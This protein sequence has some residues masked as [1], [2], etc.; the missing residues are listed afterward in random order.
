M[1]TRRVV[2]LTM[3]AAAAVGGCFG[4]ALML[5]SGTVAAGLDSS[6]GRHLALS[7]ATGPVV[8]TSRES[9]PLGSIVG[10]VP[11]S[12]MLFMVGAVLFGVAAQV[13]KYS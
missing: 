7:T 9:R 13:R 12:A 1:R 2:L 10:T 6:A 4:L 8:S 5:E 11:D 3:L